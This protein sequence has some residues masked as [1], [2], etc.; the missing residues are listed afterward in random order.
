MCNV[1]V[2]GEVTGEVYE[3]KWS[4]LDLILGEKP[5]GVIYCDIHSWTPFKCVRMEN[6][7]KQKH[8]LV[9][10]DHVHEIGA[11]YIYKG[12]KSVS[13]LIRK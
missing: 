10:F 2:T 6:Y 1:T 8:K 5:Q 4:A 13:R 7:L 9:K 11:D 3:D 12:I